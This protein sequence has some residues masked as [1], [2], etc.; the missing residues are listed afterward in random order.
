MKLTLEDRLMIIELYE[1]GYSISN[2][3]KKFNVCHTTIDKIERQYREHGI[4]SFKEKNI[5]NK[6][7][8]EFK[9]EVV[10][11]VLNGESIGGVAASLKIHLSVVQHWLKKYH[12]LGYNGFINKKKGKLPIMNPKRKETQLSTIT[13]KEKIE[14]LEK[15]IAQLEMEND[16][17]KKL[18]ALVQQRQ[19]QQN[20]K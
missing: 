7:S 18:R 12:D 19:Q 4:Q 5:N 9:L 14:N 10:S 11:R 2:L 13:D 20:K 1:K 3:A 8:N 16:L 15:K 6:Y 17:L